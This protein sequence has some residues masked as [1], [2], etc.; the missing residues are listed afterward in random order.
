MAYSDRYLLFI[1]YFN[2][3]KFSSAQM[4]LDELWLDQECTHKNFYGG[5][6]QV[7]VSLYHLLNE[8]PKGAAK[9]FERA[10][11]ML[12]EYGE[13]YEGVEV[14]SLLA[15]LEKLYTENVKFDEPMRDYSKYVPRI[16]F[17]PER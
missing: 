13:R 14:K 7:A 3:G 17:Q 4:T 12:E 16:R 11:P 1:E 5:L 9:I 10:R 15:D 8:N 6:I 2:K